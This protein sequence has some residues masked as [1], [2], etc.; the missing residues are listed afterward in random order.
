MMTG[1]K[2][3]QHVPYYFDEVFRLFVY[4]DPQT[5]QITRWLRTIDDNQSTAKDRSGR[6][7]EFEIPNLE[8]VFSKIMV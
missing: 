7:D 2:L 6:L 8:N 3:A 1:Q 5:Q 4:R